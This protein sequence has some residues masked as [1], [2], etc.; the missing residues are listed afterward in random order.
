MNTNCCI[1]EVL[2]RHSDLIREKT[3]DVLLFNGF[4]TLRQLL[5]L[6]FEYLDQLKD[7]DDKPL[8]V[9]LKCG[10]KCVLKHLWLM[11]D[12]DLNSMIADINMKVETKDEMIDIIDL[13][14]E[15]NM[16]GNTVTEMPSQTSTPTT[17]EVTNH[18]MMS[19]D[20][21]NAVE[22]ERPEATTD[23]SIQTS[24]QIRAE[25]MNEQILT[26][27]DDNTVEYPIPEATADSSTQTSTAF[28]AEER[29]A[30]EDLT[31]IATNSGEHSTRFDNYSTKYV[32]ICLLI[33]H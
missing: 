2:K 18:Q 30:I 6:D 29:N 31:P 4:K 27:D 25:I 12:E 26:T 20:D 5:T 11:N 32:M 13:S 1:K 15:D 33:N 17:A 23:S 14:D 21:N 10:L 22:Y 8:S 19:I 24:S 28:M 16:N 7:R 9:A 3:V